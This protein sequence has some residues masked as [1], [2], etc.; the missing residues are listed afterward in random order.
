MAPFSYSAV[1]SI[2][3]PCILNPKYEFFNS[4]C[5]KKKIIGTVDVSDDI[6]LF[7]IKCILFYVEK[8]KTLI[9]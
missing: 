8:K 2:G 9:F 5:I 7:L 1:W 3:G 4:I 6:Q